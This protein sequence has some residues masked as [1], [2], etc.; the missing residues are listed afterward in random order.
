M[1]CFLQ[2]PLRGTVIKHV[3]VMDRQR[4]AMQ[5]GLRAILFVMNQGQIR[6]FDRAGIVVICLHS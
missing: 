1:P 2:K 3:Q 5:P 4:Q 6:V